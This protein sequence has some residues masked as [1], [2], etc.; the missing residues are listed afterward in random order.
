MQRAQLVSPWRLK[1]FTILSSVTENL[2]TKPT[3]I[4]DVQDLRISAP[5]P[6]AVTGTFPSI[7][8]GHSLAVSPASEYNNTML[9]CF[10]S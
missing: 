10:R 2:Q 1:F 7:T 4:T 3:R 5:S 6:L 8:S 9:P